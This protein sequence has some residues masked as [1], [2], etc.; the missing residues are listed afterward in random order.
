MQYD[1]KVVLT[2]FLTS[3]YFGAMFLGGFLG[4]MSFP[5]LAAVSLVPTI[6]AFAIGMKK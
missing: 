4:G 6:I 1:K 5:V 3:T 2:A